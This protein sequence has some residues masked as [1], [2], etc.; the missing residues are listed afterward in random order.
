MTNELNQ[1]L[2]EVQQIYLAIWDYA[3]KDK[4]HALNC[5]KTEGL[6]SIKIR[7]FSDEHDCLVGADIEECQRLAKSHHE[8]CFISWHVETTNTIVETKKGHMVSVMTPMLVINIYQKEKEECRDPV[9]YPN[10]DWKEAGRD[11]CDGSRKPEQTRSFRKENFQ[12]A[13]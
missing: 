4:Q 1:F 10:T 11:P 13:A 12:P 7:I 6:T 5:V 2:D 3:H 8:T 9:G